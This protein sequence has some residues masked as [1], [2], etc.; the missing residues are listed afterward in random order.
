MLL[1]L[2][3]KMRRVSKTLAKLGMPAMNEARIEGV[4][5]GVVDGWGVCVWVVRS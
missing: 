5:C 4:R 2:V 1:E 3:A